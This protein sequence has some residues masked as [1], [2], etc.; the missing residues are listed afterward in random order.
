MTKDTWIHKY[1]YLINISKYDAIVC[2]H[3]H[4]LS[5]GPLILRFDRYISLRYSMC[6]EK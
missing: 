6:T 4:L 3:A 1:I 5:H 2:A